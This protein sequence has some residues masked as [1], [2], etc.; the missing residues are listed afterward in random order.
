MHILT[1]AEC[2]VSE[3]TFHLTSR[4]KKVLLE[5]L[6]PGNIA[7]VSTLEYHAMLKKVAS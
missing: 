6:T 3:V 1:L 2:N 7:I 4:N 5:V